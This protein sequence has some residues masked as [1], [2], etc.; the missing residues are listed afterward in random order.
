MQIPA[1]PPLDDF[2]Q[3]EGIGDG[4]PWWAD[5]ADADFTITLP[6]DDAAWESD[7]WPRP[8]APSYEMAKR[9]LPEL[10]AM[11]EKAVEY[12][13]SIVDPARGWIAGEPNLSH[14]ICD[15]RS[16]TVTLE[17]WFE[18]DIYALWSVTFFWRERDGDIADWCWSRAMAL[19]SR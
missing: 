12:L 9:I 8:H 6:D 13:K 18:A 11:L 7:D 19:R 1:I 2:K 4:R 15:A 16:E 14:L 3:Q 17:L 5:P 10:P